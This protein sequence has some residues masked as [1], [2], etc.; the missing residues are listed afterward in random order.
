MKQTDNKNE[1]FNINNKKNDNRI[2]SVK[3]ERSIALGQ[4]LIPRPLTSAS[5]YLSVNNKQK[6]GTKVLNNDSESN[7]NNKQNFINGNDEIADLFEQLKNKVNP[8]RSQTSHD[9]I[10][11]HKKHMEQ[12][13][14][15]LFM[16]NTSNEKKISS[17]KQIN[18]SAQKFE[19]TPQAVPI[20]GLS[21][22][23][24][25]KYDEKMNFKRLY[26]RKDVMLQVRPTLICELNARIK[27]AKAKY[28]L[29]LNKLNNSLKTY[30]ADDTYVN[31]AKNNSDIDTNS[32]FKNL[33]S[34]SISG[35]IPT[36]EIKIIYRLSKKHSRSKIMVP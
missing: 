10:S 24:L 29:N 32:L 12:M 9:H 25:D 36:D 4:F 2:N 23:I 3:L 13:H 26:Q 34:Q 14:K 30:A 8:K 28:N 18:N 5:D 21:T 17:N 6:Q 22:S 20:A 1:P 31:F 11:S 33:Q 7:S 35:S 27:S 15:K 19:I 16:N